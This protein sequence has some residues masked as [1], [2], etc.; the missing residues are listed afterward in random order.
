MTGPA[1]IA[2]FSLGNILC[3]LKITRWISSHCWL[4][5]FAI[6]IAMQVKLSWQV[7]LKKC[8]LNSN[9]P[10]QYMK[11]MAKHSFTLGMVQKE[12]PLAI[13]IFVAIW[14]WVKWLPLELDGSYT[15]NRPMYIIYIYVCVCVPWVSIKVWPIATWAVSSVPLLVDDYRELY[16]LRSWV[17]QSMNWESEDAA[18]VE[19]RSQ[20]RRL[21]LRALCT[22]C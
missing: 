1:S 11:S 5:K 22:E 12:T 9:I 7:K 3:L 20:P 21:C 10:K 4:A 15:N 8:S 16:F 6:S 14:L 13:P 18:A 19:A 17:S 2:I